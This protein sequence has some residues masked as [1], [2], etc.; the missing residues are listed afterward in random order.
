MTLQPGN[1]TDDGEISRAD[2]LPFLTSF[3]DLRHRAFLWPAITGSVFCAAL[4]IFAAIDDEPGFFWCLASFVSLTNLFLFYLWC[5]KKMPFLFMFAVAGLGFGIDALLAPAIIVVEGF[6]PT[7]IAPGLAEETVKAIPVVIVLLA[8][9]LLSHPWQRKFGLREPL[10]GILLAA[11]SATGFA[12]FETM[13][14]YVPKYGAMVAVPRLMVNV[15]GHIS[16]AG[17]LGYFIG[18]AALRHRRLMPAAVAILIGFGIANLMHD[19]WDTMRF[20]GG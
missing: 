9:M 10:D 4:L 15:F 8:G 5:G 13:F 16:Y 7:V 2:L 1:T 14:V 11:A 20:Y 18:L 12:F 17:T 19:L 3:R 6:L